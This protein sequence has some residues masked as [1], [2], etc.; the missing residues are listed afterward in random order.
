[1]HLKVFVKLK[2]TLKTLSSAQK[3]KKKPKNQKKTKK[4]KKTHW[5]GF[6]FLNPGFFQPWLIW[7]FT[8]LLLNQLLPYIIIL[9]RIFNPKFCDLIKRLIPWKIYWYLQQKFRTHSNLY[10]TA[11]VFTTSRKKSVIRTKTSVAD[12]DPGSFSPLDPGS[13]IE[14][15]GSR[16]F[17]SLW[18]IFV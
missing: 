16:I 4:P 2:K 8:G 3:T 1:M 17:E 9:Y 15:S 7:T 11:Y 13:G 5:A 6:F 14:F 18:T 10:G 12:P